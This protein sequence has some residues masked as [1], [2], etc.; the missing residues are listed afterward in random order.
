MLLFA[1]TQRARVHG[2]AMRSRPGALHVTAMSIC[3]LAQRIAD[4]GIGDPARDASALLIGR[5]A[6][7]AKDNIGLDAV[8]H[9]QRAPEPVDSPSAGRRHGSGSCDCGRDDKAPRRVSRD[10]V[11][12]CG[13]GIAPHRLMIGGQFGRR[14]QSR[15]F[16]RRQVQIISSSPVAPSAARARPLDSL[17]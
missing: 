14:R 5:S 2:K 1:Q 16:S 3:G 10:W 8:D 7:V 4:Q 11:C 13:H 15:H 12:R 6:D 17:L 9:G